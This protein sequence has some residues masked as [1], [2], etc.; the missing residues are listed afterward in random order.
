MIPAPVWSPGLDD[1]GVGGLGDLVVAGDGD[2]DP[3]LIRPRSG[4]A[5]PPRKVSGFDF[6]CAHTSST[7]APSTWI[8]AQGGAPQRGHRGAVV[9]LHRGQLVEELA[10]LLDVFQRDA[11]GRPHWFG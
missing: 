8:R 6:R 9:D 2:V 10:D 5:G 4:P 1:R 7:A 3:A 11:G